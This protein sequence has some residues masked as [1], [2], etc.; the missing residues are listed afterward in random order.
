M[1]VAGKLPVENW[2]IRSSIVVA[3]SEPER[4]L[5][6]LYNGGSTLGGNDRR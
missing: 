2:E 1:T 5:P 3:S 6:R 4:F